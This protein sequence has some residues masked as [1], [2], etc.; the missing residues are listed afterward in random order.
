M[1][2]RETTLQSRDEILRDAMEI[3]EAEYATPLELDDV[4]ARIATSRRHLQRV[5]KETYGAPFR[6]ALCHVRM[7]R[8]AEL[9][10]GPQPLTVRAVARRVGYRQAAQFAKAFQRHH[11][12]VPSLYR[13]RARRPAE[14][15][16]SYPPAYPTG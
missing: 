12:V 6:T 15:A 14:R 8:A 4:A 11:G 2:P 3:L 10:T 13:Q 5:F 1:P 16:P 9:L 7:R